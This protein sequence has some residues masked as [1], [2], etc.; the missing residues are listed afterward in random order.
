VF[1]SF[2]VVS[3]RMLIAVKPGG[4]YGPWV[5]SREQAIA[6]MLVG[7]FL[8]FMVAG[9]FVSAEYFSYLYFLLGMVIGLDKI[10]RLRRDAA[11]AA[12]A[13]ARPVRL[14]GPQPMP[15][16]GPVRFPLPAP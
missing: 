9:V 3:I 14:G 13:M 8:G 16:A 6:Q 7:S 10:L 15:L 2:F 5:T 11:W 12:L 1:V 4:K